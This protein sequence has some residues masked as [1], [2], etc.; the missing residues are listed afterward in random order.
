LWGQWPSRRSQLFMW[1]SCG[2]ITLTVHT[3]IVTII[4][5]I[6]AC[7]CIK[8]TQNIILL[9]NIPTQGHD[10]NWRKTERLSELVV[11]LLQS[12]GSKSR[13]SGPVYLFV[14][15]DPNILHQAVDNLEAINESDQLANS[16]VGCCV[17]KGWKMW[18]I[19]NAWNS[20]HVFICGATATFIHETCAYTW[21]TVEYFDASIVCSVLKT[22]KVSNRLCVCVCVRARVRAW[23]SYLL[24]VLCCVQPTFFIYLG[25]LQ[26]ALCRIFT[27]V[28]IKSPCAWSHS[29]CLPLAVMIML[30]TLQPWATSGVAAHSLLWQFCW[31]LICGESL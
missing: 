6:R 11:S 19:N 13:G 17:R 2:D 29:W 16:R 18:P 24:L 10:C 20:N 28:D 14:T 25:Y 22:I 31:R 7:I 12:Y 30:D 27:Q 9:Q 5:D 1:T 4:R 23:R 15:W 21:Q 26:Y 3:F 8:L